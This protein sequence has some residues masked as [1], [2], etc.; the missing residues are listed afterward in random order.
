MLF[1]L[2]IA[3]EMEKVMI[4]S[5]EKDNKRASILYVDDNAFTGLT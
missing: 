1:S 2:T 5:G 3:H 4:L